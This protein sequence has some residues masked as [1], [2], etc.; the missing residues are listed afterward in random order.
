MLQFA[1]LDERA[2]RSLSRERPPSTWTTMTELA[3]EAERSITALRAR[4]EELARGLWERVCCWL[5]GH[6]RTTERESLDEPAHPEEAKVRQVRFLHWQNL[7]LLSYRRY[8][9]ALAPAIAAAAQRR[10]GAPVRV[11]ELACGSGDMAIG[12][13][14]EARGGPAVQI[15]GSDVEPAYI[16]QANARARALGSTASFRVID[17]FAL[18]AAV[19]G[20]VDVV[21]LAQSAHHFSPGSIARIIAQAGRAGATHLVIIDGRR[22]ARTLVALPLIAS[23]SLD[24]H[25]TRDAWISARRLY[26][27]TELTLL[28]RIAAPRAR[29]SV[30]TLFPLTTVLEVA[31]AT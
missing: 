27:E 2:L 3:D 21:F 31:F 4:R 10:Q 24:R 6:V 20:E 18:D 25:F 19:V 11:L 30:R 26:A 13:A 5:D 14:D 29:V 9:G 22:S 16:A 8:R 28:A 23:A 12:L 15:T 7:A 17:A 1:E